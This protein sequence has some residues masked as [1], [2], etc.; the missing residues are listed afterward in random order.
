MK[1]VAAILTGAT[2]FVMTQVG[3]AFAADKYPTGH[4]HSPGVS[5]NGGTAFTG[6]NVSHVAIWLAV[7]VIVGVGALL[8]ARR[9][10]SDGSVTAA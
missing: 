10:S 6:S 9:R 4:S 5:G 8:V 1:R 3:S 2:V 7:L